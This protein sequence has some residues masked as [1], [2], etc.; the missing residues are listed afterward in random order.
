MVEGVAV[1]HPTGRPL[2]PVTILTG[3]LGSG[4]RTIRVELQFE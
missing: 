4:T 2:V 3:F 1:D